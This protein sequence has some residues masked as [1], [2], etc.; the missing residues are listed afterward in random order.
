MVFIHFNTESKQY[1]VSV[2]TITWVFSNTKWMADPLIGNEPL[3][4]SIDL[5]TEQYVFDTEADALS[6]VKELWA[7][8]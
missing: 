8:Q 4:P 1:V 5:V 6:K 2:A 3:V 7:L